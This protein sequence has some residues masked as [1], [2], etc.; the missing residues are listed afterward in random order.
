MGGVVGVV[1][2]GVKVGVGVG[3]GVVAVAVKNAFQCSVHYSR[4]RTRTRQANK[5][6]VLS[7]VIALLRVLIPAIAIT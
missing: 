2:V 1:G 5:L 3:I 6:S 7:R 4:I